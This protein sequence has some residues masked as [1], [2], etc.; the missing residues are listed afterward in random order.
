[1]TK[2]YVLAT[3]IAAMLVSPAFA[4][5]GEYNNMDAFGLANGKGMRTKCDVSGQYQGKTYC[6]GSEERKVEFM[7]QPDTYRAKADAFYTAKASDPNW[8]PC[9]YNPVDPDP[10]LLQLMSP[11]T[12]GDNSKGAHPREWAPFFDSNS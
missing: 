7:K 9:D 2:T 8:Q 10:Q 5:S 12:C 1:M 3:L 11:A 6:F 4:A